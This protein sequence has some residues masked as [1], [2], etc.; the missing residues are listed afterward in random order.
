MLGT[1]GDPCAGRWSAAPANAH[2]RVVGARVCRRL[3]EDCELPRLYD[4]V[5]VY[6][7][8]HVRIRR[9]AVGFRHRDVVETGAG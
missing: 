4:P 8:S 2:E 3:R 9:G 7:R 1:A 5:G 6:A